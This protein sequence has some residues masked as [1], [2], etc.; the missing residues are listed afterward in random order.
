MVDELL[1]PLSYTVALSLAGS[2]LPLFLCP[3]TQSHS[4]P[5]NAQ[6]GACLWDLS[7]RKAIPFQFIP[8]LALEGHFPSLLC[9]CGSTHLVTSFRKSNK[10][11]TIVPFA[12]EPWKEM[13]LHF[14]ILQSSQW[15]SSKITQYFYFINTLKETELS[16][17]LQVLD[18]MLDTPIVRVYNLIFRNTL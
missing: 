4:R 14:R 12:S 16:G 2:L 15:S 8:T 18:N 7:A 1:L 17:F 6:L 10:T 11:A 5:L 9:P 3:L 13:D